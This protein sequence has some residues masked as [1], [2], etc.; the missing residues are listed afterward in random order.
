[1]K[2]SK[3]LKSLTEKGKFNPHTLPISG[4]SLKETLGASWHW[5]VSM[6]PRQAFAI[7]RVRSP[8]NRRAGLLTCFVQGISFIHASTPQT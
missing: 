3:R 1:M 7:S 4:R 5:Q 6:N 2:L 8:Q